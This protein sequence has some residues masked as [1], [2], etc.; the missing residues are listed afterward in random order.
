MIMMA[1]PNGGKDLIKFEM[2]YE[3]IK[4]IVLSFIIGFV[5]GKIF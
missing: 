1:E 4:W 5:V 2:S 3:Q